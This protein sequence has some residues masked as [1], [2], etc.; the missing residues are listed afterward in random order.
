MSAVPDKVTGKK[1]SL[2]QFLV[3]F[4]ETKMNRPELLNLKAEMGQCNHALCA[5]Y[6]KH[7]LH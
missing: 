1:I 4:I 5:S 2:L 7:D 3:T 6:P